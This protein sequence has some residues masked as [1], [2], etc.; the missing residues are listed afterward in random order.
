MNL[1]PDLTET[2]AAKAGGVAAFLK[3]LANPQ[4]LMILCCLAGGEMHVGALVEATGIA[5]TS[6]SQHL[7]RLKEEGIVAV[8]REHRTLHYRIAHPAAVEIMRT[9]YCH[10]CR[11][12]SAAG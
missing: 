7:A 8:R 4:R 1:P 5:Q 12:A 6:M 10:F 9:L 3:G 11:D 2:M